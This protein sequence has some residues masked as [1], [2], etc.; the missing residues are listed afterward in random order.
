MARAELQ[1]SDINLHHV[2]ASKSTS[3]P[4]LATKRS[5]LINMVLAMVSAR[6][7]PK[8][9]ERPASEATSVESIKERVAKIAI[10]DMEAESREVAADTAAKV[11]SV[12][13]STEATVATAAMVAM[14]IEITAATAAEATTL[15][16]AAE[17][18]TVAAT[19]AM[20]AEA[21]AAE[22]D[23]VAIEDGEQQQYNHVNCLASSDKTP[24]FAFE[25][26]NLL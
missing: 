6:P 3:S 5:T 23:M 20:A 17:A 12:V 18:T 26:Q 24:C 10:V 22:V 8:A 7:S 4:S 11:D 2:L 1:S 25:I 15:A 9:P 19:Q 16:K 13:E 21:T 14:V